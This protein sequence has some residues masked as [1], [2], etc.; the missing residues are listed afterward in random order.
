[1]SDEASN[2]C[3]AMRDKLWTERDAE[4]KLEALRQQVMQLIYVC[5]NQRAEINHLLRHQHGANGVLLTPFDDL[6]NRPPGYRGHMPMGLRDKE[7]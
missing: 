6:S 2:K 5:Q 4:Q 1:M 7:I 3:V